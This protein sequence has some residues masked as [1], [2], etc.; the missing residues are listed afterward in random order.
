MRVIARFIL[1][2][3]G[4][5]VTFCGFIGVIY[6]LVVLRRHHYLEAAAIII[7]GI[8]IMLVGTFL[9]YIA[10][11]KDKRRFSFEGKLLDN[12]ITNLLPPW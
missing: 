6:G 12:I 5:F 8:T 4:I 7:G 2:S 1:D 9:S 10:V 11:D 3:L